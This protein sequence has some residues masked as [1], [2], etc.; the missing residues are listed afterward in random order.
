VENVIEACRRHRV[1]ASIIGKVVE[2]KGVRLVTSKGRMIK[3]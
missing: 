2:D 1:N 3:L